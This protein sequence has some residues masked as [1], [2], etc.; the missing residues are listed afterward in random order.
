MNIFLDCGYYVGIVLDQYLERNEIDK[1]WK[2]YAFEPLHSLNVEESIKRFPFD[3]E[4]IDK[5]VWIEDSEVDFWVSERHNASYM[6]LVGNNAPSEKLVVPSMDFSKFVADLPKTDKI[7]C[8]MDIEG[9]EYAVLEKMIK[10]KTL[11]R[12]DVLDIEFHH[13]ILDG[14]TIDDSKRLREEI[15]KRGIEIRLKVPFEGEE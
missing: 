5:A 4:W 12:I 13:R 3:I 6:D 11:D 10:D 2:V 8:S 7:I 9:A 15:L 14:Y 1:D